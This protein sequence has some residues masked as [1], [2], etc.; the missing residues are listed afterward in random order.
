MQQCNELFIYFCEHNATNLSYSWNRNENFFS[1]HLYL[2]FICDS[3]NAFTDVKICIRMQRIAAQEYLYSGGECLEISQSI[4]ASELMNEAA[5][6]YVRFFT[7][8]CRLL[9]AM[10]KRDEEQE[11]Y[12]TCQSE[13]RFGC[14]ALVIS[15]GRSLINH[16]MNWS[17]R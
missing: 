2:H 14:V 9:E 1:F 4:G 13:D 10:L 5:S 16:W 15:S 11:Q 6:I 12:G 3:L 8:R 17:R 7:C